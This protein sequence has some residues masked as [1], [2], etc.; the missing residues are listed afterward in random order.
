MFDKK[1]KKKQKHIH[2]V[3][4]DGLYD[5]KAFFCQKKLRKDKFKEYSFT[6]DLLLQFLA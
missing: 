6:F 2:L 3:T 4:E 5:Q 1:A